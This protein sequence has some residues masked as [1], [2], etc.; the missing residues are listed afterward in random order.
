MAD[1]TDIQ[2]SLQFHP[3]P[4]L[5]AELR[6]QIWYIASSSSSSIYTVN[7][8]VMKDDRI[9]HVRIG[10][11]RTE[12][13][14]LTACKDSWAIC[15]NFKPKKTDIVRY[16]SG[17]KIR[18][19]AVNFQLDMFYVKGFNDSITCQ[20]ACLE[21]RKMVI[22]SN[23]WELSELKLDKFPNLQEFWVYTKPPRRVASVPASGFRSVSD[24]PD[25]RELARHPHL[26]F[27]WVR[28]AEDS[29]ESFPE[30]KLRVSKEEAFARSALIY[31]SKRRGDI[32][33]SSDWMD[34]LERQIIRA[35][36]NSAHDIESL[37]DGLWTNDAM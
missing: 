20:T 17:K 26:V 12:A 25:R 7:H 22:I 5:P 24:F 28:A 30:G 3:F 6:N 32:H 16:R 33:Q 10:S 4:R 29:Q 27:R 19:H 15:R 2:T 37:R 23:E 8:V 21:F 13:S 9:V 11:V 31:Y 36:L 18:E 14:L 35:V 34:L 1:Q